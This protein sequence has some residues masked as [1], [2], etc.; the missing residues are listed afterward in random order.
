MPAC[1]VLQSHDAEMADGTAAAGK[2][3]AEQEA[4]DA[5]GNGQQADQGPLSSPSNGVLDTQGSLMGTQSNLLHDPDRWG[6]PAV[7]LIQLLSGLLV[8]EWPSQ[9]ESAVAAGPPHDI[10]CSD[11]WTA[12]SLAS[13]MQSPQHQEPHRSPVAQH[14]PG[15]I[16]ANA[17]CTIQAGQLA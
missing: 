13:P 8:L 6:P 1:T 9:Y 3:D 14:V 11:C 16:S 4:D 12:C 17:A 2:G 7:R 15:M 10:R 5:Q